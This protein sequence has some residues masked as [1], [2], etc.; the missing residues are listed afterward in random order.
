MNKDHMTVE[1]FDAMEIPEEHRF[2]ENYLQEKEKILASIPENNHKRTWV[3][4]AGTA[5]AAAVIVVIS[6]FLF[7]WFGSRKYTVTLANGD[8]VTY[9][10]DA[11]SFGAYSLSFDCPTTPRELTEEEIKRVFPEGVAPDNAYASFQS[12]TGKLL[13]LES[14]ISGEKDLPEMSIHFDVDYNRLTDTPLGTNES[15]STV[16]GVPVTACYCVTEAN[17]KGEKRFLV[18]NAFQVG[19]VYAYVSVGGDEKDAEDV[20][21]RAAEM[22]QKIINNGDA[23]FKS[24][25]LNDEDPAIADQR[26][27]DRGPSGKR[28]NAKVKDGVLEKNV[29][30][31][32]SGNINDGKKWIDFTITLMADG[33]YTYYESPISSYIGYGDY[34]ISSD[35]LLT[36]SENEEMGYAGM[37]NNFRFEGDRISFIEK[38]SSNFM[39]V[40]VKDGE[41]FI[42]VEIPEKDNDFETLHV[43]PELYE[44]MIPQIGISVKLEDVTPY[45]CKA[46]F[47]Y[48][49]ADADAKLKLTTEDTWLIQEYFDY[50]Y[51]YYCHREETV[52]DIE[53]EIPEGDG[54]LVRNIDWTEFCEPLP[55]G[56]YRLLLSITSDKD[57]GG[58]GGYHIFNIVCPF[59]IE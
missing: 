17:S 53:H 5:A 6:G 39:Y 48:K 13:H 21:R 2:S 44:E 49:A 56:K 46:V 9:R 31:V 30:F 58:D 20:C 4:I 12:D 15:A 1:E 22:T 23:G 10:N 50:G 51:D 18:D 14:T 34:T 42:A 41:E 29:T 37:K 7:G 16:N 8:E 47:S 32:Y 35:G 55:A 27:G 26:K 40:K 28:I 19:E 57:V 38:G 54:T 59:T 24:V 36:M 43:D 33:R 45:G 25:S 52:D 11:S 3:M